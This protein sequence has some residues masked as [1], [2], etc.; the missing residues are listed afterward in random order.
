VVRG[1]VP[2]PAEGPQFDDE[3]EDADMIVD[4]VPLA[5]LLEGYERQCAVSREIVAAHP[6]DEVG[7]NRDFASGAA[8]LRWMLI[9]VVEATAR[10]VGHLDAVREILDGPTGYC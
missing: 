10:H 9:H 2:R 4:G 6:L 1:A 5:Q 7:R 3:V 8:S